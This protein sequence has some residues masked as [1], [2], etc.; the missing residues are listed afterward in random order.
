MTVTAAPPDVRAFVAENGLTTRSPA[1]ATTRT[2]VVAAMFAGLA[3]T[4]HWID[5]WPVW[6]AIWVAQGCILVGSYSAMHEASHATLYRSSGANRVAGVLWASTILVNWSL[7][8]SFHLQHHAYTATDRDP[9]LK[10]RLVITRRSQYLLVPLGGLAFMAELWASSLMTVLG[11]PPAYVKL[12]S[13]RAARLDGLV[14]LVVT[15]ALVGGTWTSPGLFGSLWLGP[16]LATFCIALPITGMSEHYGCALEGSTF[17]TTRTVVSNR[18]FRFLVW[19]NN[20]HV[21]H[22]L[23]PSVPFH[24]APELHR[25]IEPRHQ[26]LE[27]S[28][29]AF[30]AR[31]IRE[32]GEHR[33]PALAS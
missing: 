4:G 29:L 12:A 24:H 8:R 3:V 26:Y 19:N 13:R 7:W 18:L 30:H 23:V 17:D 31:I 25:Y 5:Q 2:F 1:R 15:A 27:Q 16:L 20:F 9:K 28:Y 32:C 33:A 22:H 10:H 6:L 14:L 11:R 21:V